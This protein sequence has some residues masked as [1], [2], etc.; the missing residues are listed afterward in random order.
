[1]K[2]KKQIIDYLNYMKWLIRSSPELFSDGIELD[3]LVII[4]EIKNIVEEV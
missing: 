2:N 4:K 1:M 3:L